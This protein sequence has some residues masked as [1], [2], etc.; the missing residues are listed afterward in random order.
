M[1]QIESKLFVK[2]SFFTLQLIAAW[3]CFFR[4][5]A[6]AENNDCSNCAFVDMS[7]FLLAHI[8]FRKTKTRIDVKTIQYPVRR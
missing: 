4:P 5:M 2:N 3:I 7:L 1:I 6:K 8:P